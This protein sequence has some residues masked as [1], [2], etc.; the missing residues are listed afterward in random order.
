MDEKELGEAK[1]KG[2]KRASR[3]PRVDRNDRQVKKSAISFQEISPPLVFL[4]LYRG[5]FL[6]T[7]SPPL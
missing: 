4:P 2:W 7:L 1:G 6:A 5:N 3:G